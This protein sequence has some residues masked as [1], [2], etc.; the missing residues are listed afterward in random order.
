[1]K[2]FFDCGIFFL[3]DFNKLNCSRLRNV[4]GP[5]QIVPFPTRGQSNLDLVFPILSASYDVPKKLPPFGLSDHDTVEVRPL[6]RQDGPRNKILLKSRDP[7]TINRL[8]MRT[9]LDEVDLGRLVGCKESPEEKTLVLETIIE[10]G[11]DFVLPFKS[12]TIIANEPPWI[13]KHLK[14]LIHER[15]RALA[16]GDKDCFRRLRNRVNRLRKS[17]RAK[18]SKSNVEHLR[19]CEPRRWWKEV[20]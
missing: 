5:R 14:S 8:A 15:Q 17:C 9:Y 7:R 12:K 2:L 16:R 13:S 20:K 1:M 3:G 18:Y 11:L 4:F 19:N 6:A 10:T